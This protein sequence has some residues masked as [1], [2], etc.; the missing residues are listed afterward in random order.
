MNCSTVDH[1]VRFE[2]FVREAFIKKEH[3][4]AIFFNLEKTYDTTWKHGILQDLHELGFR[5]RLPCFISN[6][7]SDNLFQVK[8][9][10]TLSDFHVQENMQACRK[11]STNEKEKQEGGEE[12]V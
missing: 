11:R 12:R 4:I 2:T 3:V 6:F 5:G 9:G 8:I 1:L 7:L 10:S